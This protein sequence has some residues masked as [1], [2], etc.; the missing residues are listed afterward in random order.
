MENNECFHSRV[1]ILLGQ[2][3]ELDDIFRI[4]VESFFHY[5]PVYK[6][7]IDWHVECEYQ[8]LSLYTSQSHVKRTKEQA[9]LLVP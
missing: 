9:N 8:L 5:I 6:A 4:T 1:K 7:Y 3:I 2:L